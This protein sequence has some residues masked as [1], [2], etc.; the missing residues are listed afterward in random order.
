MALANI[1]AGTGSADTTLLDAAPANAHAALELPAADGG[2]NAALGVMTSFEFWLSVILLVF[3]LLVIGVQLYLA[4]QRHSDGTPSISIENG[5]RLSI[6]TMIIVGAL[7]LIASGYSNNQIAP[8][9]G[10]F[11]TVAGYLIGKQDR[12]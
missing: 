2:G 6:V 3:G 11:G 10:L 9:M 1:Q 5:I 4:M 7:V 8:A 12:A